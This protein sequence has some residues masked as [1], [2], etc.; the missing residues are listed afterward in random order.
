[1]PQPDHIMKLRVPDPETL[2]D[3]IRKYF[4]VCQEKLGLVP[5]VLR[6]YGLRPDKLRAFGAFYNDLML[7]E[8][9]LSALEREMVAVVV[10]S[11]NRCYYCLVAHGAAVRE[12]SGDPQLGEMLV[13]NYRV[14]ELS[15]RQR[16]ILDFAWKL[17]EIPHLLN[18]EDR[19]TLSDQ[20]LGEEDIFDLC[21]VV[22]FFNMTNRVALAVD[23]MPN[24]EYHEKARAP[25]AP[26][27]NT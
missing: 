1:M 5:Y 2:D 15:P 24:P 27:S 8:S 16:T 18:D 26:K 10:S 13:M 23:M 11:V 4:G 22:G 3:D 6:A 14:A 9:G 7:G 19:G 21:N 25:A 12:L 20:G 17:T